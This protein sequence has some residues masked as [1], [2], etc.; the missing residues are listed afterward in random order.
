MIWYIG[1]ESKVYH[2]NRDCSL[3]NNVYRY[4]PITSA[5]KPPTN[6]RQCKVCA[7]TQELE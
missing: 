7:K 2:T 1:P 6:R 3:L 4:W 5:K